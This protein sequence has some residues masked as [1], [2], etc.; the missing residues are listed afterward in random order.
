MGVRRKFQ[1]SAVFV[2]PNEKPI[3]SY[4]SGEAGGNRTI[5]VEIHCLAVDIIRNDFRN[6]IAE[7]I[8]AWLKM[9][10]LGQFDR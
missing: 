8:A 4:R 9:G 7:L 3:Q 2:R 10:I 5:H 6:S 1:L